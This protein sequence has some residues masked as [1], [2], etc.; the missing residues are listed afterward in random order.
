M[1]TVKLQ[2]EYEFE[3]KK[4]TEINM[5]FDRLTGVDFIDIEQE[6]NDMGEYALTPETSPNFCVRLAAKAAGVNVEVIK[7]LPIKDFNRVKNAARNFLT[8]AE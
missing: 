5:D 7:H 3:G 2:N 4:Y 6:M 1:E 8:A